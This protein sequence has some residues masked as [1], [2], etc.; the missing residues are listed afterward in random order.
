MFGVTDR[1]YFRILQGSAFLLLILGLSAC[2]DSGTSPSNQYNLGDSDLG[3]L[4]TS[5]GTVTPLFSKAVTH[6]YVVVPDTQKTIKVKPVPV[7]QY[8]FVRVNGVP[9]A[10]GAFTADIPL[11]PG[12]A[13]EIKILVG[14]NESAPGRNYLLTV[15][16]E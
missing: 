6:Y 16:R 11:V 12:A 3:S 9:V 1:L 8:S 4:E 13:T 2:G 5:V 10:Y 7:M 14:P 15:N